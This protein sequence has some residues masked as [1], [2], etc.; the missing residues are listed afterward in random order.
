MSPTSCKH[1]NGDYH[2][3]HCKAGVCYRDVTTNPDDRLGIAFRK[4]CVDWA[5]YDSHRGNGKMSPAQLENWEQR[6]KCDKFELPSKEELEAEEK[7]I[8]AFSANVFIARSAI[9]DEL[10]RRWLEKDNISA[11]ADITNFFQPQK[12]YYCGAGVMDCPICRTGKLSYSRSSY[13]GH[14]HASCN[15]S[16]CVRWME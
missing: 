13:N 1:Y 3:T 5:A 7:E 16:G 12:N 6:G 10:R 14:V 2:N 11:P 4:P 9:L 8:E 15:S